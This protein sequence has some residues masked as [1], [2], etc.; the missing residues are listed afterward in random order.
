M[1][2][3]ERLITLPLSYRQ[4]RSKASISLACESLATVLQILSRTFARHSCYGRENFHV[5]RTG[6]EDF[7]HVLKFYANFFAKTC[8]HY[9]AKKQNKTKRHSCECRM[10]KN[11]NKLHSW[12]HREIL[13]RMC[14]DCR[15]TVARLSRYTREIYFQS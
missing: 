7:K 10:N 11:G 4:R 8:E 6:C 13:S 14:R 2:I 9:L 12:E 3:C 5:S 1:E 15:A